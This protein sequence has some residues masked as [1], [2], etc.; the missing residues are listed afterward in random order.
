MPGQP[1]TWPRWAAFTDNSISEIGIVERYMEARKP[2][3]ILNVSRLQF[4]A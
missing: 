2:A 3:D 1:P 4:L